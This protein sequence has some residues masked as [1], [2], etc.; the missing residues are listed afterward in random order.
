MRV[1][2]TLI[3]CVSGSSWLVDAC[4][5]G[6]WRVMC[7]AC[8]RWK[9]RVLKGVDLAVAVNT[10]SGALDC[11]IVVSRPKGSAAVHDHVS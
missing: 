3:R 11:L 4:N 2:L 7:C 9:L 10:A 6:M 1:T 5:R 8:R